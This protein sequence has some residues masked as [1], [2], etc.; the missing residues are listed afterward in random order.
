[1]FP[2]L[3]FVDVSSGI[4]PDESKEVLENSLN[5]EEYILINDQKTNSVGFKLKIVEVFQ[6]VKIRTAKN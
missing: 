1:M 5:S 2:P 6:K 3:C 4:V